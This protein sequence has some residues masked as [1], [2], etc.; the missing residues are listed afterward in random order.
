MTGVYISELCLIGLFAI[1]TS[2]GP[3][4]LMIIFLVFTALYHAMMRNAL[5]PMAMYLPNSLDGNAQ[6]SMFDHSDIHSYDSSNSALPPSD[7]PATGSK[8]SSRKAPLFSKIFD[9]RKWASHS[10]VRSLVPN[11]PVPHYELDEIVD[12]YY[13]PAITSPAPRLW[14]VRDEMGISAQEVRDSRATVGAGFEISDGF[15]QFNEK[16]KVTWDVQ[17]LESVPIWEKRVD[18]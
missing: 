6:L 4:V 2:P 9:P 10:S 12:A 1:N 14:I 5:R 16:G 17:R 3:L 13:N 8:V 18:Y 15:A 7:A 11:Y